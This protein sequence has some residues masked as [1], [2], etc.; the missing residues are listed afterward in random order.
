[1]KTLSFLR[2]LLP[3]L[4]LVMI[5]QL[6]YG[7]DILYYHSGHQETGKI[8]EMND[9]EIILKVSSESEDKALIVDKSQIQP[10]I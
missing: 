4:L 8:I 3:W 10:A 7:Q 2:K 6:A 9:D 1:M 5:T